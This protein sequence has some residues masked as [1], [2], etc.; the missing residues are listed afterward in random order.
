[1]LFQTQAADI[2]TLFLSHRP[3]IWRKSMYTYLYYQCTTFLHLKI[4]Q[5][6]FFNRLYVDDIQKT[7]F[8]ILNFTS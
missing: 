4:L 3:V 8:Y 6:C 2:L 7:A 5:N 1:M